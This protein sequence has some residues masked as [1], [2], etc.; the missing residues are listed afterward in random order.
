MKNI[1]ET[2]KN[3]DGTPKAS[4]KQSSIPKHLT[5][6]LKI[7]INNCPAKT[8]QFDAMYW[9]EKKLLS[10]FSCSG[11]LNWFPPKTFW[12][13]FIPPEPTTKMK[14]PMSDETLKNSFW[15]NLK[16]NKKI[17]FIESCKVSIETTAI[18]PAP[19]ENKSV[20]RTIVLKSPSQES[21][22]IAPTMVKK[23]RK[24]SL[25]WKIAVDASGLKPS[26]WLMK[27]ARIAVKILFLN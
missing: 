23:Y 21:A 4:G 18:V 3:I 24:K 7:G 26:F 17:Y 10:C 8:P 2:S 12:L 11:I 15:S 6:L 9:I 25:K 27:I 20:N 13:L 19:A 22:M 1:K 14:S 16:S 5:S